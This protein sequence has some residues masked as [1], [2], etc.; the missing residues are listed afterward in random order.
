MKM[1][2]D[3]GPITT[4]PHS[5]VQAET[6]RVWGPGSVIGSSRQNPTTNRANSPT[7]MCETMMPITVLWR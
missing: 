2:N 4:S 1:A 5:A 7:M 6:V 3:S